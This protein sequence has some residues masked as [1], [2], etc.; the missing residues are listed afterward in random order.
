M[1]RTKQPRKRNSSLSLQEE[2]DMM[3]KDFQMQADL[4]WRKVQFDFE[5]MFNNF[6]NDFDLLLSKI[7]PEVREMTLG[8]LS[9]FLNKT[10]EQDY[11]DVSSSSEH[12]SIRYAPPSTVKSKPQSA[13]RQ[14]AVSTDDGYITESGNSRR[15][16]VSKTGN[17]GRSS[18]KARSTSRTTTDRSPKVSTSTDKRA[19]S[20]SRVINK[21]IEPESSQKSAT[22]FTPV[23]P[24]VKPNT[25]MSILRHPRQGEMVLSMQGS[26]ILVS[27][28]VKDQT[29][30]INVPLGDGKIISLLPTAGGLRNSLIPALDPETVR[31]LQT[32]MGHLERVIDIQ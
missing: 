14:T 10:D 7:P 27:S 31:Q 4:R 1:P 18:R 30:N 9:K 11:E 13:K 25:P 28:I 16:R 29:A 2:S 26:P 17:V 12:A 3:V 8:D 15:T 23:T 19:A 22:D 6:D 21:F 32:L 24:K 20:A 5:T